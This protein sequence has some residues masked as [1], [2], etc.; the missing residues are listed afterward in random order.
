MITM[1]KHS[2]YFTGRSM[3]I[4][5]RQPVYLAFTLL[6]P[7]VWLLLFSQLF[8]RVTEVPGFGGSSYTTF[9]APGVLVMTAIMSA[10][11]A[12]TLFIEDMRTGVMDRHLTSPASRAGLVVGA[13]AYWAVVTVVQ[14]LI[15]LAVGFAIGARYAGGIPGLLAV[16]LTAVLVA[17]VFA[18]FSCAVALNVRSQETLIGM[19]MFLTLPLVFLSSV[20]MA[21]SLLPGWIQ[22]FGKVNPVNWASVAVRTALTSHPDWGAVF[23]RVGGLLALVLVTATMATGAFRAYKEAA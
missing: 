3:R 10:N 17:L 1:F 5:L 15:V 2:G 4:L 18:G 13:M 23:L 6:Q 8:R 22:G 12:G 20:L 14:G 7:M 9:L 19:S 11:W 16:I 21:P